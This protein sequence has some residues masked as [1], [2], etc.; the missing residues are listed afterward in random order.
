MRLNK[1]WSLMLTVFMLAA[2]FASAPATA[3]DEANCPHHA[4]KDGDKAAHKECAKCKDKKSCK[5]DAIV[6]KKGCPKCH[7]EAKH[8]DAKGSGES[9]AHG[10]PEQT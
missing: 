8:D 10:Q 5:H 9:K 4:Q 7:H 1:H 6:A 2:P 3:C